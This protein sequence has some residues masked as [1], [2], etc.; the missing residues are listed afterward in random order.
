LPRQHQDDEWN[1]KKQPWHV[2]KTRHGSLKRPLKPQKKLP[3]LRKCPKV[4]FRWLS[5]CFW[6]LL[7]SQRC[8]SDGTHRCPRRLAGRPKS[9]IFRWFFIGLAEGVPWEDHFDCTSNWNV[10]KNV[11]KGF[12]TWN[13]TRWNKTYTVCQ[14]LSFKNI[15]F[16]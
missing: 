12:P 8:L 2:Q 16:S 9:L 5:V 11:E 4:T 10:T 7:G 15:A 13:K 14:N 6:G 1:C 3:G